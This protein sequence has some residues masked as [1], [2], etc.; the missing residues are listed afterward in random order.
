MV[1]YICVR[2]QN[3]DLHTILML[4]CIIC[5]HIMH[6][7]FLLVYI[8]WYVMCIQLFNSPR[9]PILL[10]NIYIHGLINNYF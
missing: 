5:V 1:G 10:C 4:K 9:N 2:V 6:A 3:V 7:V 8:V